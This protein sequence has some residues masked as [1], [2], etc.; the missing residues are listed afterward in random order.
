MIAF[1]C[2]IIALLYALGACMCFAAC[3]QQMDAE[4]HIMLW[5][6]IVWPFVILFL[7]GKML[8]DMAREAWTRRG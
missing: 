3:E 8:V 1:L 2:L 4:P 7:L 6:A 5:V